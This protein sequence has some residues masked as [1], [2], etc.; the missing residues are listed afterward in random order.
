V[1]N[2]SLDCMPLPC[3]GIL[4]PYLHIAEQ[5]GFANWML[6]TYNFTGTSDGGL[7]EGVILDKAGN[8][9]GIT[10]VGGSYGEGVVYELS[11]QAG[12]SW[13]YTLLHTFNDYNGAEPVAN[14][15]LGPDGKLYGTTA[16]G[17]ANGGGVVFQLTP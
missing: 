8:L 2:T 9:Y 5:Y 6:Q 10:G 11:P 1:D 7:P 3:P 12:G 4:D 13:K 15:T 16:T 14:L 17:G